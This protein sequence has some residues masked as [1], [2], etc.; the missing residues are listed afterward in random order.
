MKKLVV[1][2]LIVMVLII[3]AIATPIIAKE[4]DEGS[5]GLPFQRLW[6]ELTELKGEVITLV[7]G[8]QEQI[9][10]LQELIQQFTET[11]PIFSASPAAGINNPDITDWNEA[12]NWGDHATAGYATGIDLDAETAARITDVDTEELTRIAHD[13]A[14]QG[15]IN[16]L[17]GQ[18]NSL[19]NQINNIKTPKLGAWESK[20]TNT[21][22]KAATDGF[23]VA[24]SF[25]N[26]NV[27]LA[28]YTDSSKPPTTMVIQQTGTTWDTAGFTMPVRKNDYWKI[29]CFEIQYYHVYWIPFN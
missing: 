2:C 5:N 29:T 21:V 20:S 23:V 4:P 7:G 1:S 25:T 16:S 28:G 13:N 15:Q 27:N 22:Y 19:Q 17:Q 24:T 18:I 6:D 8:L 14:L 3:G 26:D 11:D 12:H 9:E 10:N